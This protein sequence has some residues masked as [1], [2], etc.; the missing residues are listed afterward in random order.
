[1]ATVERVE[2]K[3]KSLQTSR[4]SLRRR[5]K[6]RKTERGATLQELESLQ[7]EIDRANNLITEL[8]R[9]NDGLVI[10][11]HAILRYIER[12]LGVNIE[13]IKSDILGGTKI[14]SLPNGEYPVDSEVTP[15]HR[16]RVRNNIVVTVIT[17]DGQFL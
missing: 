3:I 1:M 2:L 8:I 6:Q 9:K 7:S 12:V 13:E 10:S 15:K 4:E 11:E 5:L 14:H 16:I 17:K